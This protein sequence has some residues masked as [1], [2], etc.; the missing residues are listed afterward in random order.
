MRRIRYW[1][2]TAIAVALTATAGA[3]PFPQGHSTAVDV[4]P[5]AA[6]PENAQVTVT[7]SLKLRDEEQLEQ[8]IESVSSQGSSE[9]HHFLTAQEFADR[10]G[11]TP[12][13]VAAVTQHFESQGLTVTRHA[14]AQLHVSGSVAAIEKVFGVQ[15]HSFAVAATADAPAFRFRAPLGAAHVPDAIAGSVSAVLGLDTRPRMKPALQH[16]EHRPVSVANTPNTPDAP[17]MWTVQDFAQYYD[18]NPLYKAGLT[19]RNHTLAIMTLASFTP[20][21]AYAYWKALGLHVR[22]DRITEIQVDGG[23]GPPSDAAGSIETTLDVE[24]SGGIAPGAD[25]RV[26]EAPNTSQGFVD[27]VGV[28]AS[29]NLADTVSMSW[30]T[31]E[32]F[33]F[34]PSPFWGNGA[35]TDPATGEQTNMITAFHDA[36]AQA[37]VQGQTV[38]IATGDYGAYGS[39]QPLPLQYFNAVLSVNDPAVQPYVTAAGGTTLP[40]TQTFTN[41]SGV[42]IYSVNI[43]EEQAWSWT[44]LEGLCNQLG[45]DYVTCGIYPTG[46]G[47][48]VSLYFPRPFYQW[49]V[50]GMADTQPGQTI[51]DQLPTPPA[52]VPPV[53][54][55]AGFPGRN[56]PDLSANADPETG[57]VIYY[58]SSVTG[59]GIAT[60]YGGT[61]FVAPQFNGVSSLYVEALHQRMGLLNPALYLLGTFGGYHGPRAPLR[62]I[63]QGNNWYWNARPGYDQTTGLGVPDVANLLESLR[64]FTR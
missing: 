32:F 35:V 5:A 22:P 1:L 25:I 61:S 46:S 2:A 24:Q 12:A 52:D 59:F 56:V 38:F 11:P 34:S 49:F 21:D 54:F 44:Y 64:L 45:L 63:T 7:V 53:T 41:S 26:Y 37:A 33:D 10:F 23:S 16:A 60:Y 30:I 27:A 15:L 4:G 31:W 19:G 9:Y 28:T 13:A 14:T 43:P 29:E 20:S 18:V 57:Y 62:D 51:Y 58:T 48:G 17:G 39:V 42:P 55:P 8:L 3:A 40:G 6:F 36:L 47:G 50:P